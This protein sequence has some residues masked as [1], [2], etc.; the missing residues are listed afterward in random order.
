MRD[1]RRSEINIILKQFLMILELFILLSIPLKK[2][3]IFCQIAD[4]QEKF[5]AHGKY[6]F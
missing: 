6:H 5:L 4:W 1:K 3:Q 2:G